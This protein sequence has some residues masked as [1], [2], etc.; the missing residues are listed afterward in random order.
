[1]TPG[2]E[3]L[4]R[5]AMAIPA[6]RLGA[7]RMEFGPLLAVLALAGLVFMPMFG[8]VGA[9]AFLAFGCGLIALRPRAVLDSALRCWPL[10]LLA[11][12]CILSVTWSRA[13]SRLE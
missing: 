11:I 5:L 1:M 13:I 7:F 2:N 3:T 10:A 12:Y 6:G 4:P 9:A 8:P